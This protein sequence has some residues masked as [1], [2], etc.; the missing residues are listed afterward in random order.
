M[1]Y[2]LKTCIYLFLN[3]L[4]VIIIGHNINGNNSDLIISMYIFIVI[5][6]VVLNEKLNNILEKLDNLEKSK[7]DKNDE[8]IEK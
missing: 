2:I 3:F 6:F 4:L 1:I 7:S 5:V 8:R